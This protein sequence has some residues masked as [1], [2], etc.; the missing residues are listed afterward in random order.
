MR[1]PVYHVINPARGTSLLTPW[2]SE[3]DN[4][5]AL[6][7]FTE[8][9]GTAFQ[10]SLTPAE[11]LVAAV[12][13]YHPKSNDFIWTTGEKEQVNAVNLYGYVNQGKAFYVSTVPM[14]C[15]QPIYRL[16]KGATHLFANSMMER[17]LLIADGWRS[18]NIAFYAVVQSPNTDPVFSIAVMPDTQQEVQPVLYEPGV[19]NLNDFRFM[20]RSR[21]LA[22]NKDTL[23]LQFVLHSGDV[24][25]WG[26]WDS[27][28]Y[29]VASDAMFPLEQA[30]IPYV[31]S[32]GNHDTRAVCTNGSACNEKTSYITVRETPLFN[33]YFKDRFGNPGG[34]Y[35]EGSL[36]NVYSMFEAGS[37]KWLVL[38][39]E[40]WPRTE[41][42]EWA[43]QVVEKY[44]DHNVIVVTHSYLNANGDILT[45][46]GGYGANSPKYLFDDLISRYPNI[47]FVFSGHQGQSVSRVD[48][49]VHGNRIVSYLQAFHDTSGNPVRILE[50]DTSKDTARS[51]IYVPK[52]ASQLN[53]YDTQHTSMGYVK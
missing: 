25:N 29:D 18:E 7:G 13:L 53:I 28:Q 15:A 24:V 17:D 34:W 19:R 20:E 12:R 14:P 37:H 11:G 46:N 52:T 43:K 35:T 33:Q 39:L 2:K 32:V 6:Y 10:A 3:A 41:V 50:I 23:N 8:D 48:T 21:W 47:R 22:D 5:I 36:A 51:Y 44:P 42:I 38:S 30:G 27:H 26:E 4:A 45:H 40:L 1:A 9:K 16:A 31:L 49:G